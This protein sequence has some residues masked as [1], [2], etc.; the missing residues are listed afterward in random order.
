MPDGVNWLGLIQT[1]GVA[2]VTLAFLAWSAVR[3]A[4]WAAPRIEK[5]GDRVFAGVDEIKEF[6]TRIVTVEERVAAIWAFQLNRGSEELVTKGLGVRNS[7]VVVSDEAKAWL[8]EIAVELRAFYTRLGRHLSEAEIAADIY[9]R[10]GKQ[11]YEKVCV[12]H[13]LGDG[14][15]LHIALAVAKEAME[16][17]G[18]E[19]VRPED[20]GT[21]QP[22]SGGGESRREGGD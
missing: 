7:P 12:P 6:R 5:Y 11:I 13:G 19:S 21:A 16:N 4:N 3:V 2:V 22:E 1:F 20:V 14:A 18:T 17:G 8:G 15:C 9:A 10:Y